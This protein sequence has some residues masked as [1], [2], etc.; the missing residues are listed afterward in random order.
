MSYPLKRCPRADSTGTTTKCVL[1]RGQTGST[2]VRRA[3]GEAS[4]LLDEGVTHGVV[5]K[6]NQ[7]KWNLLPNTIT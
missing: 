1:I 6:I 7:Y 3:Y 5:D 2:G 4:R